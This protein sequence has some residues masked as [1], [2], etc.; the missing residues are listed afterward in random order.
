MA[1]SC[2]QR[3]TCKQSIANKKSDAYNLLKLV[4]KIRLYAVRFRG[5]AAESYIPGFFFALAIT[6]A[7]RGAGNW[8]GYDFQQ[9]RAPSGANIPP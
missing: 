4:D 8:S 2:C 6:L 5:P 1:T 9:V 3:G 7:A